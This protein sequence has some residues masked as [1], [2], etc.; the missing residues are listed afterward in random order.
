MKRRILLLLLVIA[1]LLLASCESSSYRHNMRGKEEAG[2]KTEQQNNESDITPTEEP[3]EQPTLTPGGEDSSP[4]SVGIGALPPAGSSWIEHPEAIEATA[5]SVVKLDVYDKHG[6]K[7]A[8]GTAFAAI[9]PG[10]LVTAYH[11]VAGMEYAKATGED[12]LAF[13]LTEII[14]ADE[15]EDTAVLKLPDDVILPVIDIGGEPL[16]GEPTAVI[17]SQAGVMNLVTM[18]NYN[19]LYE[20]GE[21]T[22][23]L[24]STPV[25]GGC[26]GAPLINSAGYVIG[27][28][29][30]TYDN[31][32]NLNIAVP[33]AVAVELYNQYTEGLAQ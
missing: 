13:T 31:A 20:N 15:A 32:Q 3:E 16:R 33:M 6:T 11:V 14:G 1:L 23:Y 7:I 4:P 12:G 17:G 2:K 29:S 5:R 28:V 26:S 10:Y 25:A 24:F 22:R 9:E 8:T 27:L 21:H 18:G 30:G 19:G